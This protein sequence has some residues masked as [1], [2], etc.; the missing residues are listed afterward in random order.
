MTNIDDPD[1][2]QFKITTKEVWRDLNQFRQETR[3]EANEVRELLAKIDTKLDVVSINVTHANKVGE[4]HE[5]RIR[6]IEKTIWR[7][8]GAAAFLGA[9]ASI[10]ISLFAK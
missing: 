4:D 8:A 3:E 1:F 2:S 5:V 9:S 10:L 6:L 7:T